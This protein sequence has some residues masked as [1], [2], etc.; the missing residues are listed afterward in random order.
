VRRALKEEWGK[1]IKKAPWVWEVEEN[2]V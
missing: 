2:K 1:G